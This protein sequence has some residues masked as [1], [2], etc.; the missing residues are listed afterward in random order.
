MAQKW[1]ELAKR[2]PSQGAL[3]V[4]VRAFNE[5]QMSPQ[6]VMQQ[7]QQIQPKKKE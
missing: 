4:A 6:P 1:F 7:Q 3:D 2:P 5:W